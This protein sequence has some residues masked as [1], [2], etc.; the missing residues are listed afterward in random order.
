[1]ALSRYIK[2]KKA[3]IKYKRFSIENI[4]IKKNINIIYLKSKFE[5]LE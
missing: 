5:N 4:F 1:M 3:T 2:E